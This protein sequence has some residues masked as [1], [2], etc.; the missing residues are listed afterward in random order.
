MYVVCRCGSDLVLRCHRPQLQLKFDPGLAW[1]LP[2]ATGAAIKKIIIMM[3]A[4]Y[5]C[6]YP[7]LQSLF[8]KMSSAL[9]MSVSLNAQFS[10]LPPHRS[11]SQGHAEGE[12]SYLE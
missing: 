11:G 1:E 9:P 4:K 7:I 8:S 10:V 6:I 5:E 12:G 3:S 2:Y